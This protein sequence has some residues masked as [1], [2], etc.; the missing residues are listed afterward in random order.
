MLL[1]LLDMAGT[2]ALLLWGVHMVE[3]GVQRAY[4]ARLRS[5]LGQALRNRVQAFAAGAGITAVLQ[6]S[7]AT[8]LMVTGFA[9][10]G[11]I[12]LVPALAVMLGANVGSTLIVQVLSFDVTKVAPIFVLVGLILFRRADAAA[13]DFGRVFIG[14]GLMLLALHQFL[15]LLGSLESTTAFRTIIDEI[16]DQPLIAVLIAAAITWVVHS[17]VA[18]VLVIMSLAS[19]G[20][21]PPEAAFAFVIGAN[22]GTAMN[23]LFEAAS[24]DS[25]ARRLPIGNLAIR[26]A[27][28]VVALA[29]FPWLAPL[30]QK[31][32]DLPHAVANFHT[33]FNVALA[34]AFLP[35]LDPYARLLRWL[36]PTKVTAADPSK[37]LY[38]DPAAR[39]TPV[40]ALGAAAREALRMADFLE[41]MLTG[42]KDVL[43]KNDR[44]LLAQ[45]RRIDDSVDRINSAI[46]AYITSLDHEA[47]SESD[48][49]RLNDI[50]SFALN[51]E[52]AADIVDN[53]LLA[54]FAKAMKR[55]VAFSEEGRAELGSMI[56]RLIANTRTAAS[57]FVSDDVRAARL[58]AKQKEA[59]RKLEADA[60]TRH[61]ER[62]RS[63]RRDTAETSAMHLDAVRDLKQVNAHLV[64]A[65]AYP[66]LEGH[67]ELLQS[68]IRSSD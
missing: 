45:T 67:G 33:L 1:T 13:R 51:V 15:A 50:L 62:L 17:S 36:L 25:A 26:L 12:D 10:G 68:R 2:V 65:A 66:V 61:F 28:A 63:G 22:I 52:Q 57:L 32:G 59:F 18:T 30:L 37:P 5:V 6:S 27:G 56:D 4:G 43:Q 23:P 49:R 64:A 16:T 7:T 31:L 8:G 40:V 11:L 55:G 48:H 19:K 20:L 54:L 21:L 53:N 9:A 44:R 35:L 3:T 42:L 39:A 41:A 29:A 34:I 46:K 38:L 24:A 60:V 58:M 14:L 47:L